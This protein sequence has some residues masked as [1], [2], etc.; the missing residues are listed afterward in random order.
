MCAGDFV[1]RMR[2]SNP[3]VDSGPCDSEQVIPK[4]GLDDWR[5]VGMG[6]S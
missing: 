5:L 4:K 1:T 6:P 3:A 2:L